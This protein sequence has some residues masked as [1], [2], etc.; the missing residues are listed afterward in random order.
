MKKV[1]L[2]LALAVLGQFA[3]AQNIEVQNAFNYQKSAQQLID[4]ADGLKVNKPEKAAKRMAD[5]KMQ[6]GKAKTSIDKASTNDQ[7]MNQA[8]TWH[9]YAVIYYKIGAYPEFADLDHDAFEK[10]LLA[11]GKIKSIDEEYYKRN[12]REFQ[13]YA[14]NIG[15]RYYDL[16]ANSYNESD[17]E[18]AYIN[19]KKAYDAAA[20]VG[21]KD[22]SALLNAAISAMKIE[23]YNESI[24]M[25]QQ[26]LANGVE[27]PAVYQ[28]LAISYR[29]AGDNDKMI[30]IIMVAREKFPDD[31]NIMNEMINSY[32]TVHRED[33]IIDQILEMAEKNTDKPVYYFILGTIYGNKESK[34]YNMDTALGYY[35]KAIQVDPDYVNAYI[36]A[37]NVLIDK[38]QEMYF[39]SESLDPSSYRN[40]DAY[41]K[42]SDDIKA[43]AQKY[44]ARALPYI[45]RTNELMPHEP[46]VIQVLKG[47]YV[48]L[49]MNDKAAALE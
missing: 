5:A 47:I 35:D 49:N 29:G 6:L 23:R 30:E 13:T 17:F 37:G 18:D 27:E 19:F 14:G 39:E 3:I 45:E 24:E 4:E 7:T 15:A 25:L 48:R 41:F 28:N 1:L 20:T 44:D 46:A 11:F 36:N 10:S 16:G 42:A 43:E 12:N 26:M 40:M 32:L 21:G 31:E 2:T 33:E 38:A 9:Y 22:N 34:L 8:K